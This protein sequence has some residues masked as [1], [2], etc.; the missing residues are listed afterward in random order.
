VLAELAW[1]EDEAGAVSLQAGDVGGKGFVGEVLSSWV[2]GDTDGWCELAW[3]TSLLL[4]LSENLP[5][6]V[7][8]DFGLHSYLQLGDGET[9]SSSNT[10]V[11]LDGWAAD[12]W[13]QLVDWARSDSSSLGKTGIAASELAARLFSKVRS[14]STFF[15]NPFS[16]LPSASA[17]RE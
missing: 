4:Y 8:C 7:L 13:S 3:D 15:P 11:V 6:H 5:L 9:T 16:L 12:D 2:D 14:C 17:S 10:A 1:E